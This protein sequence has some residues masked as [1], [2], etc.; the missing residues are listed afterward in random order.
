[1]EGK[2]RPSPCTLED[3]ASVMDE[4]KQVEAHVALL[5]MLHVEAHVGAQNYNLCNFNSWLLSGHGMHLPDVKASHLVGGSL[6]LPLVGDFLG[7]CGS[8]PQLSQAVLIQDTSIQA[9]F[10][11]LQDKCIRQETAGWTNNSGKLKYP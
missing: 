1:M 6:S 8:L 10:L 5:H 2:S 9:H 3:R 11:Q 7:N 4:W